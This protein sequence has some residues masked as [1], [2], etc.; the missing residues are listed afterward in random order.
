MPS[1]VNGLFAGRSGISSHGT[2]IAVVADNISNAST[3]GFKTS[4]AEFEDLMAGGQTAGKVVG[5]GSQTSAVSTIFE[6]G[7]LEFT[8]RPLDLAIDGNGFFVLGQGQQ[9][10]YTR[11]GNF[12]VNEDGV[13]VNQ[14]GLSVLGFPASGSGALEEIN[15]N[16]ISQSQIE[17]SNVAVAGNLDSG[18]TTIGAGTLPSLVNGSTNEVIGAGEAPAASPTT[19]AELSALAEFSTVVDVFDSLG[20]AHTVTFFFFKTNTNQYTAQGYVN[21]DDVDTV[22]VVNSGEPRLVTTLAN[23][24]GT[25]N[26][27]LNFNSD[28]SLNAGTSTPTLNAIIPWNTGAANAAIA[29]DLS[30][31]TQYATASNVLGISQD[32]QGIGTVTSLSIEDDGQ[33]FALL[34]NG[35]SAT[36]GTI[37]LV[38]FSNPEGLTRIGNNLLQQSPDSGEP[39]VG[40]PKAGTLGAVQSGSIELSTVDIAD[41][42]VK[43]ITLQRGFQANSRIIT[44]INQLLNE[45]IQLA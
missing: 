23:G 7:T 14:D 31:F 29:L 8:N 19:Y 22:P 2:A 32:G 5:S 17:S 15:V 44:T 24:A 37:G 3:I 9:R 6:Q 38:N 41:Q 16:T 35:Q 39:I 30:Q 4:R 26:M 1:I 40:R 21:S 18:S 13:I 36:I 45:I 25:S 42:F 28:G 11:A 10:Y 34:S 43:L 33:I 12:K 27:V 20:N